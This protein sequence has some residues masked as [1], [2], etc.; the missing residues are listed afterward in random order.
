VGITLVSL[1]QVPEIMYAYGTKSLKNIKLLLNY[2][3]CNVKQQNGRCQKSVFIFRFNGGNSYII[4]AKFVKF[5]L[6]IYHKRTC[7]FCIKYCSVDSKK[8]A[9]GA[10]ALRL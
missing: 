9:E 2:S 7:I 6:E 5:G 1:V 3:L 4:E 10:K 8:H